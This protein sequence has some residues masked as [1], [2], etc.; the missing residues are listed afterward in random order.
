MSFIVILG[1]HCTGT[2][3]LTGVLSLLGYSAGNHLMP[4]NVFNERGY[5]EDVVLNKKLDSFLSAIDRSWKDERAHPSD[6][7]SSQATITVM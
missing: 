7:L 5:F 4:E 3:S 2:S 1:M 6:W